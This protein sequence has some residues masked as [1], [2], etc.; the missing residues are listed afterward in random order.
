MKPFL[1]ATLWVLG[2]CLSTVAPAHEPKAV[3]TTS[4]EMDDKA[5]ARK[6]VSELWFEAATGSKVEQ[7]SVRPPLRAIAIAR[8]AEP[9]PGLPKRPLIVV[10]HGNWGSRYSQ[11][12]LAIRLVGAGYV[13]LSTSH[14]GTLGDDQSAAGRLRLWDRSRDVSFALTEVLKHPKW[15]A[16]IDKDRIGFVGHSFGGWTGVSLAGATFDPVRQRAFCETS[17]KRD[18]YCDGT[19]KDDISGVHTT[20]ATGSFK[21]ARFKAFYIMATGPG[22]GFSEESLRSINAPFVVDTAESDEILEAAANS[23]AL[24]K[25]ISTAREIVRPVGHFAYVP[26][27]K[28]VIG[29]L[30]A[31]AAGAPICDDPKGVDRGLLHKQVADDVIDF[32]GKQLAPRTS[33]GAAP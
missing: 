14:P 32:F 28:R 18:F 7:F 13:V 26:E 19:L 23:S 25:R 20:D 17:P 9:A 2:V 27:C 11:G 8:N 31:R 21:D 30:L 22:Q 5:H 16:L 3:G 4:I 6:F 29:T 10:S 33:R 1:S 24:A 12:W 15:S